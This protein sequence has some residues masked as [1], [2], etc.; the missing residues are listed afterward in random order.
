[1]QQLWLI[2]ALPLIGFLINGL[3]GRRMPKAV[4]SLVAVL[5]VVLSFAWVATTIFPQTS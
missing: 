4:I 2:P 3:F 1:M 5:S